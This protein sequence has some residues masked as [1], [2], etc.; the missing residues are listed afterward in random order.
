MIRRSRRHITSIVLALAMAGLGG[1][2]AEKEQQDFT[3]G[4]RETSELANRVGSSVLLLLG[5]SQRAGVTL[6]QQSFRGVIQQADATLAAAADL[7]APDAQSTSAVKRLTVRMQTARASLVA[8]ERVIIAGDSARTGEATA[9]L[10][11]TVGA[12]LDAATVL[13]AESRRL[14]DS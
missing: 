9:R 1:C 5:S 3:T 2:E 4:A 13:E 8:A 6:D 7:R 12:V 10:F 14:A 11:Q